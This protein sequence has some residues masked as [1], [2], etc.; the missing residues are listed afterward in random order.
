MVEAVAEGAAAGAQRS[1]QR[2][3]AQHDRS[4]VVDLLHVV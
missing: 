3:F 2:K 4:C 1:Q